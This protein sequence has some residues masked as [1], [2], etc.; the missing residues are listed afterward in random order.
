LCDCLLALWLRSEVEAPDCAWFDWEER[1]TRCL[2]A[3]VGAN[4]A[5]Y[6]FSAR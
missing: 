1:R 4:S 2:C 5:F 6:A 3:G